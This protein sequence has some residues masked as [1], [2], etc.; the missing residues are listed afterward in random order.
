[1]KTSEK[2]SLL[3]LGVELLFPGYTYAIFLVLLKVLFL[4]PYLPTHSSSAHATPEKQ[5]SEATLAALP[6]TADKG[7][8]NRVA[9]GGRVAWGREQFHYCSI[10]FGTSI[11]GA[12]HA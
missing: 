4:S 12:G 11:S 7:T 2:K 1:M 10:G 6:T 8:E 9:V 3:Q 5:G